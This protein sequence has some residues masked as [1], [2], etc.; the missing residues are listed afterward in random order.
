M[1]YGQQQQS[2]PWIPAAGGSHHVLSDANRLPHHRRRHDPGHGHHL[3]RRRRHPFPYVAVCKSGRAVG[4][5][6]ARR[7]ICWWW[8]CKSGERAY[9]S[10]EQ[11]RA[12]GSG[13]PR[14]SF[15]ESESHYVV[16]LVR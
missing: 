15:G 16:V 6:Q 11:A 5:P 1:R 2:P 14:Q 8:W 12:A 10:A 7:E 9:W 4:G 3:R 13:P